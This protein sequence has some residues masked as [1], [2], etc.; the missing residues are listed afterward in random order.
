MSPLPPITTVFMSNLLVCRPHV[1]ACDVYTDIPMRVGGS[2]TGIL[3]SFQ[4]MPPRPRSPSKGAPKCRRATHL[5]EALRGEI[6]TGLGRI[7][8]LI[9][10]CVQCHAT[11]TLAMPMRRLGVVHEVHAVGE[12]RVAAHD[13]VSTRGCRKIMPRL[14]HMGFLPCCDSPHPEMGPARPGR[15]REHGSSLWNQVSAAPI[16]RDRRRH[17]LWSTDAGPEPERS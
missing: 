15:S 14:V 10:A 3:W 8:H 17:L 16:W 13:H 4:S 6:Y 9:A 2:W 12:P 1:G 7:D 11:R 5:D